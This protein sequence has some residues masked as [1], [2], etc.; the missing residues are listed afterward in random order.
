MKIIGYA[1]SST[2]EQR[3]EVQSTAIARY[4][5]EQAPNCKHLLFFDHGRSSWKSFRK[6]PGLAAAIERIEEGD[7][8][9][10]Q[11]QDRLGRGPDVLD[12]IESEVARRG[13]R[14]VTID[15]VALLAELKSGLQKVIESHLV[16]EVFE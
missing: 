8:L 14:I 9:V 6:R 5:I 15:D 4:M 16:R 11:Y 2:T 12:E 1:R 13:G 7:I 3:L 10:A